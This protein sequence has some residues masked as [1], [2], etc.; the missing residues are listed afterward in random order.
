MKT[1]FHQAFNT[2]KM[3]IE[4]RARDAAMC[5]GQ[6]SRRLFEITWSQRRAT[7][8]YIQ[9]E[10]RV[11]TMEGVQLKCSTLTRVSCCAGQFLSVEEV[12]ESEGAGTQVGI[13]QV[14]GATFSGRLQVS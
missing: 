7:A 10:A 6:C 11:V 14:Q 1:I 8:A 9:G 4:P 2:F 5:L 13:L 12:G 3:D